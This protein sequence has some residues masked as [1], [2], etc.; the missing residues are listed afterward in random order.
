MFL[1]RYP[2]ARPVSNFAPA[3]VKRP[4]KLAG[5]V[6]EAVGRGA[7]VVLLRPA[8]R[9]GGPAFV[10]PAE[11]GGIA[12]KGFGDVEATS[13]SIEDLEGEFVEMIPLSQVRA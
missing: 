9:G 2:L 11:G 12:V 1:S 5:D 10:V 13:V 7:R 3:W 4:L 8:K 6:L